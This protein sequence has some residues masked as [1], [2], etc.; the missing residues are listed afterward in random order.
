M[1]KSKETEGTTVVDEDIVL[2]LFPT[3]KVK[4]SWA[5]K[6]PDGRAGLALE[7]VEEG[8]VVFELNLGTLAIVREQ[9][10]LVENWLNEHH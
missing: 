7:S 1:Q 5:V 10:E 2:T 9:L 3:I 8:P 6:R 4:S